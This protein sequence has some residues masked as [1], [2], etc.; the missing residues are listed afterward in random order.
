MLW[1]FDAAA[2]GCTP[3]VYGGC[4]GTSNRFATR[5]ACEARCLSSPTRCRQPERERGPCQHDQARYSYVQ[6]SARC[7]RF[8]YGGCGGSANNF[9]TLERCQKQCGGASAKSGDTPVEKE[10]QGELGETTQAPLGVEEGTEVQDSVPTTAQ[11][12]A[13]ADICALRRDPGRCFA[14]APMFYFDPVT[15]SCHLFSYRGCG[16]NSNRF[17]TRQE[18][19]IRC[20]QPRGGADAEADAADATLNTTVVEISLSSEELN[21]TIAE[22]YSTGTSSYHS[23]ALNIN[24]SRQNELLPATN[25]VETTTSTYSQ[26][27]KTTPLVVKKRHRGG[28][29][30]RRRACRLPHRQGRCRLYLP[31]FYYNA[32]LGACYTFIFGGC[33]GNG[34]RFRTRAACEQICKGVKARP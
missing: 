4:Y 10:G 20:L 1:A 31:R 16:G 23:I 6:A 27:P 29:R 18:C 8:V 32:A 12:A 2:G 34:N 26:Q 15:G 14:Y 17:H 3:F 28:G 33:G 7:E 13:A 25:A 9:A 19:E 24:D 30:G 5:G 22:V 21:E 11:T